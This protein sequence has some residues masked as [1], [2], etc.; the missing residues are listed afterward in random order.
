MGQLCPKMYSEETKSYCT[1]KIKFNS[2][3]RHLPIHPYLSK[4]HPSVPRG[5]LIQKYVRLYGTEM[6]WISK[7]FCKEQKICVYENII[8]FSSFSY[9]AFFLHTIMW[10]RIYDSF[11]FA[12][13]PWNWTRQAWKEEKCRKLFSLGCH[14]FFLSHVN[15]DAWRFYF[16]RNACSTSH[17]Y[18]LF[19][20]LTSTQVT[21]TRLALFAKGQNQTNLFL[22]IYYWRKLI[23]QHESRFEG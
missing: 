4:K 21:R 5:I 19:S 2:H 11:A 16:H 13:F 15:D 14:K 7:K 8:I 18:R 23:Q 20:F 9:S 12:W 17:A 10:K 1:F 6:K 22:I 3:S